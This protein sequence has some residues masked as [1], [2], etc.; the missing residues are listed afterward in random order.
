MRSFLR[1]VVLGSLVACGAAPSRP[2]AGHA[3]APIVREV[4]GAETALARMARAYATATTYSDRWTSVDTVG[5]SAPWR[6]TGSTTFVRGQ[7][8]LI[9]DTE[10]QPF[11]HENSV[12]SDFTHTYTRR[13]DLPED[14]TFDDGIRLRD[15]FSYYWNWGQALDYLLP[16]LSAT[17]AESP[18]FD[19][20]TLREVELDG[21]DCWLVSTVRGTRHDELWLDRETYLIR[22]SVTR[23]GSGDTLLERVTTIEPLLDQPIDA[24]RLAAPDLSARPAVLRPVSPPGATLGLSV[25]RTGNAVLDVQP[26]SPAARA[27]IAHG[28]VVL[29]VNGSRDNVSYEASLAPATK[30]AG[31][32]Y[33]LTVSHD[34]T[35]R[36]ITLRSEPTARDVAMHAARLMQDRVAPAFD[37][38]IANGARTKLADYRGKVLILTFVSPRCPPCMETLRPLRAFAEQH[39]GVN[40]IVIEED[41]TRSRGAA[42]VTPASDPGLAAAA[43]YSVFPGTSHVVL[44]DQQ[45][46]VR[47]VEVG[48]HAS[49]FSSAIELY[50]TLLL[51][52]H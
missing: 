39:P 50:A 49:G 1:L 51:L 33:M 47:Y 46:V 30:P 41:A 8:L 44:I 2:V 45:G 29:T 37:L 28:D 42:Q 10:E 38:P 22:K 34:G 40:V 27:G 24:T 13:G 21:H 12:W 18:T 14:Q 19:L 4:P 36:D 3:C 43:M 15:A 48:P 35:Q 17:K 31:T 9:T 23:S 11:A 26:D 32:S 20:A 6:A 25:A 5:T 7:R 16:E 52:T